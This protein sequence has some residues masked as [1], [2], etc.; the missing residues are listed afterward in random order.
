MSQ[1]FSTV[2]FEILNLP[3]R[4]VFTNAVTYT[5]AHNYSKNVIKALMIL[6]RER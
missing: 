5:D 6:I 4:T 1:Y 2:F 3:L